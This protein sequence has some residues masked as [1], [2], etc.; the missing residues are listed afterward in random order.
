M[1]FLSL[2]AYKIVPDR[3]KVLQIGARPE[4][5]CHFRVRDRRRPRRPESEFCIFFLQNWKI[6]RNAKLFPDENR[7]MSRTLAYMN[8]I[9]IQ[10]ELLPQQHAY[11][12][13]R[14]IIKGLFW[15]S[16]LEKAILLN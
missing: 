3:D 9:E 5:S 11:T 15:N 2:F 10:L 7:E 12:L 14:L 8:R 16:A 6:F 4:V 13:V 1:D